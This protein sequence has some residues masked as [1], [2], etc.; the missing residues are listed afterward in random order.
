MAGEQPVRPK[1]SFAL[2]LDD[3]TLSTLARTR[4]SSLGSTS[5]A[6]SSATPG[7]PCIRMVNSLTLGYFLRTPDEFLLMCRL[8]LIW[9][10]ILFILN[11]VLPYVL[12]ISDFRLMIHAYISRYFFDNTMSL[13]AVENL[14]TENLPV[15][16]RPMH[17][18][19][20]EL[21]SIVVFPLLTAGSSINQSMGDINEGDEELALFAEQ[22]NK[23]LVKEFY[24]NLIE[25]FGNSESLAYVQVYVRG[26]VID[27]SPANIAHYLSCP[28]CSD[29]KGTGLEEEVEFGEVVKVLTG[30]A[31]AV[32][33]EINRLNSNLIKMPYRALFRY[34]Y[35]N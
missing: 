22:Y 20:D 6:T 31:G 12:S 27:F 35:R 26:H 17:H 21:I 28:H 11:P 16:A 4:Y 30:D 34:F 23:N 15:N 29:I 18:Y 19:I 14:G 24:G 3:C 8:R 25:E 2:G 5:T 9:T 7:S 33:L 1:R 32:W 10:Q 13:S